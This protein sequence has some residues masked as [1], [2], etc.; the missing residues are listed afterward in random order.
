MDPE[1]TNSSLQTE[2]DKINEQLD[3]LRCQN[4]QEHEPNSNSHS[5]LGRLLGFLGIGGTLLFGG[6]ACDLDSMVTCYIICPSG[7]PKKSEIQIPD[8]DQAPE[9]VKQESQQDN[10]DSNGDQKESN[11]SQKEE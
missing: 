8:L 3:Q 7:S 10:A 5:R 11:E 9:A 2:R 4:Q 1:N 6:T